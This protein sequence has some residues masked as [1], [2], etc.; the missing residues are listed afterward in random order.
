MDGIHKR[1]AQLVKI[2]ARLPPDLLPWLVPHTAMDATIKVNV[3]TPRGP[4]RT[5][6]QMRKVIRI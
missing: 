4:K 6:A 2:L 5:A 1:A 3:V